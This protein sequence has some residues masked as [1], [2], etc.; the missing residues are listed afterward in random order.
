MR[1][2]GEGKGENV[3]VGGVCV[4]LTREVKVSNT[5]F[6][7]LDVHGQVDFAS[8]RQVFDITVTTMLRAA[9]DCSGALLANLFLD[10]VFCAAGMDVDGLRWLGK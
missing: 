8:A 5:E 2:G 4:I 7:A 1:G 9:G 6:S 3:A 10:R